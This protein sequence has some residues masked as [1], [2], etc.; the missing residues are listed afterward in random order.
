MKSY[1]FLILFCFAFGFAEA[2]SSDAGADLLAIQTGKFKSPLLKRD[3]LRL[4]SG[5]RTAEKQR[6]SNNCS[7]KREYSGMCQ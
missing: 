3:L 1:I 5:R 6:N 7:L 2:A 4:S